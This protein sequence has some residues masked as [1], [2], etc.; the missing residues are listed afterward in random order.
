MIADIC[1]KLGMLYRKVAVGELSA[2][3]I[4]ESLFLVC[5][6]P[7]HL[8]FCTGDKDGYEKRKAHDMVPVGVGYE[9]GGIYGSFGKVVLHQVVSQG[10]YSRTGVY[11][12]QSFLFSHPEFYTGCVASIGNGCF[13]GTGN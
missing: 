6:R 5:D 4:L 9:K 8:Q 2:D 10:A 7:V 1:G 12:K 13:S 11:D 3:Y